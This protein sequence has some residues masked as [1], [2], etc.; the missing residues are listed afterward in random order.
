MELFIHKNCRTLFKIPILS[1]DF[2]TLSESLLKE[3]NSQVC[4]E[5]FSKKKVENVYSLQLDKPPSDSTSSVRY[6]SNI[7]FFID[8]C[9]TALYLPW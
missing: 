1:Y 2:Q 8:F 9:K 4:K 3:W 7:N 5:K 6:I